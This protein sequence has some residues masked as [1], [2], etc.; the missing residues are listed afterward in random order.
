MGRKISRC[1]PVVGEQFGTHHL[2]QLPAGHQEDRLYHQHRR[3]IPPPAQELGLRICL[4][5]HPSV[6]SFPIDPVR[7]WWRCLVPFRPSLSLHWEA[8][9]SAIRLKLG[10]ALNFRDKLPAWRWCLLVRT[11]GSIQGAHPVE[12]SVVDLI[13]P[14]GAVAQSSGF[15]GMP[16]TK[17]AQWRPGPV[18]RP[19]E[20]T[21]PTIWP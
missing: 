21:V 3:G 15:T 20:P 6:P 13:H 16:L 19:V 10:T 2:L 5:K 11:V 1:Y 9:F 18:V 17:T 12:F 4:P 7:I 14:G 8:V